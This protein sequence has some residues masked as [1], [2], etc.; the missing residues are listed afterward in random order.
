MKNSEPVGMILIIVVAFTSLFAAIGGGPQQS[1]PGSPQQSVPVYRSGASLV[2]V[3]VT[4]FDHKGRFVSGLKQ[5]QFEVLD[6]GTACPISIFEPVSSGFQ[7]ALLLDRTG[8]MLASLP[9]L[10]NAVL[11]FVDEFRDNDSF[12]IYSFNTTLRAIQD[13]TENKAA[14]KQAVLLTLA[15]GRTALVDSLSEVAL[16]IS[17][18]KGKKVVVV[19]TDGDD[20]S[21]YLD[22]S[23]VVRRAKSLGIPVYSVA[24]GEALD[25][26]ELIKTLRE[27]SRATGGSTYEVRRASEIEPVF[28]SI[29]ETLRN[30]YMIAYTPPT[31]EDA[32]WRP[33]RVNVKGMKDLRIHA[34]EGYYPR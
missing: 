4:V 32:R 7:C 23:A 11:R 21:S 10:K 1:V 22:A 16:Q 15:Q 33:L 29:S 31:A 13:F 14:A 9:V 3:Y 19:F 12:A 30:S 8:S 28:A 20:N 26:P 17:Q 34:R 6:G 27:M 25:S 5:D 24:Q 18:R 2:E